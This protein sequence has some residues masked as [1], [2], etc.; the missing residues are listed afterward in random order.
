VEDA[1][2]SD[3]PAVYLPPPLRQLSR[4]VVRLGEI[5]VAELEEIVVEAWLDRAPRC[6]AK[7]YLEEME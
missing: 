7:A 3:E 5:D 1:L 6:L 4:G 2:L